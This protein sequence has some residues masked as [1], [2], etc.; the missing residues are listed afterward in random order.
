M[1][2]RD[3]WFRGVSQAPP[4]GFAECLYYGKFVKLPLR[5]K[6]WTVLWWLMQAG[7][8]GNQLLT[9]DAVSLRARGIKD[10]VSFGSLRKSLGHRCWE[11]VCRGPS[12]L[13]FGL[14]TYIFTCIHNQQV[15]D[16]S[17]EIHWTTNFEISMYGDWLCKKEISGD[18]DGSMDKETSI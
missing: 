17:V 14:V 6:G 8:W 3:S 5:I 18:R 13:W 1:C 4:E 9:Q 2:I 7:E 16:M 10:G 11:S 15:I 12:K